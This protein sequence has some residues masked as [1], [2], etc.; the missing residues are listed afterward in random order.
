MGTSGL[1]GCVPI[2]VGGT[3]AG[4]SAAYDRRHYETVIDDQQIELAAMHTLAQ[5]A[6]VGPSSRIS[7]TSYNR[8][9]LLTGQADPEAVAARAADLV[10]RLPKVER[11][12]D[13]IRIGPPISLGQE[14]EDALI[15]SRAKLALT[16]VELPGFNPTRVKVVTED[17]TVYLMGLVTPAEAAAA[18]EQ[19]SYVPGVQQVVKLFE[20]DPAS[21]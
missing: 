19:I 13:E 18:A 17:A 16:K 11:V 9:L 6:I 20:Y 8:T 4:A 10:S 7:A 15:T 2:L 5:D 21:T 12:V 3:I 1:S 14:S